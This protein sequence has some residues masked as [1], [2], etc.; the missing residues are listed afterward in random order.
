MT[1]FCRLS[2]F[3]HM[4]GDDISL[5]IPLHTRDM[6]LNISRITG[7]MVGEPVGPSMSL[8]PAPTGGT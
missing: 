2:V 3:L 6:M 7:T 4:P 5:H 8:A 1:H